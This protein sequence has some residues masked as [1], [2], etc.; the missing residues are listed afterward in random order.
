MTILITEIKG[1]GPQTAKT[2]AEHGYSNAE[3]LA[4]AQPNDLAAISG[5]GPVRAN[6]V[7][8]AAKTLT[9]VV[10]P[11]P[12]PEQE[13]NPTSDSILEPEL[14]DQEPNQPKK[15]KTKKKEKKEKKQKKDKIKKKEKKGKKGKKGK[16][17]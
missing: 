3:D 11:P 15:K 8:E 14:Q 16:K 10:L 13:S 17:K 1:I 5:F 2:L 6:L 9:S 4:T 12:A 7:I